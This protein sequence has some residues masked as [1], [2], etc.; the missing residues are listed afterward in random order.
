M[1]LLGGKVD[2]RKSELHGRKRGRSGGRGENILNYGEFVRISM[3]VES[4][5][6]TRSYRWNRYQNKQVVRRSCVYGLDCRISNG[7]DALSFPNRELAR[8][9]HNTLHL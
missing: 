5:M 7:I 9:C 8:G 4:S 1:L 3:S 2:N 6:G